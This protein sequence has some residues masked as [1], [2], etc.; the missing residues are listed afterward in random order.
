MSFSP[1]MDYMHKLSIFIQ[2]KTQHRSLGFYQQLGFRWLTLRSSCLSSIKSNR[3]IPVGCSS[4][5]IMAWLYL[6][7][8]NFAFF[9][10]NIKALV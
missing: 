1:M 2:L 4:K 5:I 10:F 6:H 9:F 7:S 8:E 3:N